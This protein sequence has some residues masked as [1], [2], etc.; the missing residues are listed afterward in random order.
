MRQIPRIGDDIAEYARR[1]ED[2]LKTFF[3]PGMLFEA[4]RFTYVGPLNGHDTRMMTNV[5]RQ[6]H[7]LEGPVLVHVLTKKGK[8]YEPAEN[9]PVHFHGEIGRAHV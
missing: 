1:S 2:S 5:F 9:N 6:V 4:F 7:E 8:G 3:T